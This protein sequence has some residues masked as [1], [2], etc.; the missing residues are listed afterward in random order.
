LGDSC[1][2]IEIAGMGLVVVL[3]LSENPSL[4]TDPAAFPCF[5]L[6]CTHA[7]SDPICDAFTLA[8][9]H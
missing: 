3:L 4:R 7:H 5:Y 6:L 2:Q 1:F 9:L 8:R